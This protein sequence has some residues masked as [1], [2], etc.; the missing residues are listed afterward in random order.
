MPRY[1]RQ[2]AVA[3]LL[4][5]AATMLLLGGCGGKA[6]SVPAAP[7]AAS[8]GAHLTLTAASDKVSQIATSFPIEVPVAA[9]SV[10]RGEAQGDS[11]WI[12]QIIVPGD[13]RAVRDWY[14]QAYQNS[15]WTV[16]SSTDSE[17]ALEKGAA[18]SRL[19][20]LE[21]DSGNQAQTEIT[22]AVGVGTPVLQTQ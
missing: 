18:Q 9:G 10:V 2:F 6:A 19:K 22:A 15:E 13:V 8:A 5:V 4:A 11:A 1:N 20:F 21:V 12:Y 16:V 14:L 17:I 3:G 7:A